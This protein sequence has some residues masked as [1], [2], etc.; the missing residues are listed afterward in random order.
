MSLPLFDIPQQLNAPQL[1]SRRS[2][3]PSMEPHISSRPPTEKRYRC[4][5]CEYSAK[6]AEHLNRH[7]LTHTGNRPF[8]CPRCPRSFSRQDALQRH[9][10]IHS[11]TNPVFI[12][13]A[14]SGSDSSPS[15]SAYYP[16]STASVPQSRPYSNSPPPVP[17]PPDLEPCRDLPSPLSSSHSSNGEDDQENPL[18]A[19]AAA[20]AQKLEMDVSKSIKHSVSS[21]HSMNAPSPI[22]P[23]R[24]RIDISSL[25]N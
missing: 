17:T 18:L 1:T 11:P 3:N 12:T 21:M 14:N 24:T 13:T 22:H 15:L 5:K 7:R 23:P 9:H 16:S 25:L 20:C 2:R 8:N 4:N 10:R 19:L 6:R